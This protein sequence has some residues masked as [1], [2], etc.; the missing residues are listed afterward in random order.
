MT[1]GKYIDD[2]TKLIYGSAKKITKKPKS[3]EKDETKAR[4]DE[5]KKKKDIHIIDDSEILKDSNQNTQ[6]MEVEQNIIKPTWNEAINLE[7]N[8][9]SRYVI[10]YICSKLKATIYDFINYITNEKNNFDFVVNMNNCEKIV[11]PDGVIYN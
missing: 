9:T 8:E 11:Y 3:T 2:V 4:K 6:T 7:N 1:G 10:A 5:R